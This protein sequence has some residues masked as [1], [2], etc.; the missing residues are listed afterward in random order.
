MQLKHSLMLCQFLAATTLLSEDYISVQYMGY[1]EDSGR[2]TIMAPS[3][4]ISK[5]FGV[6]YNLKANFIHDA[7]SGASP[8]WYDSTSGA[9]VTVNKHTL[10]PDHIV[11]DNIDYEEHRNALGATLTSRFASRDELSIGFH[12][13]NEHDYSSFEGSAE[14][15]YY[16]DSSK[17]RSLSIGGSYQSNEV[18][19]ECS[20]NTGD[21]DG[22]SG[23]SVRS[24]V[25]VVSG[26]IGF[27][28]ILDKTSLIKASVFYIGEEGY[29]SNPYMRVVRNYATTPTI[30]K[31]SKPDSRSAYGTLLQ[32]TKSFYDVL[33]M[34]LSYRFYNDDWKLMSHTANSALYY[35]YNDALLFGAGFRYYHQSEASFYSDQIDY[36]TDEQYAS[37]DRRMSQFD[38]FDYMIMG[39]YDISHDLSINLSLNYYDQPD[40]FNALSYS[41]AF[42]Y[43]F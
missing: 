14:Y 4:E 35:E 30:T 31:E 16:L 20:L 34:Q 18:I 9:S 10:N 5:D 27:T 19:I 12:Y 36:F 23:A 2:T 13:S 38:A 3:I 28:Q 26:E 22:S 41:A 7:I 40:H 11:Y 24:S 1:D 6:D 43:K 33:S 15:L 42:I 29:L 17:N 37:S 32:Y 39:S 25:N 21:C 8:T